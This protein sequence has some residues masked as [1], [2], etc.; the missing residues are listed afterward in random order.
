[1]YHAPGGAKTDENGKRWLSV[2]DVSRRP[3]A[4][5][6]YFFFVTLTTTMTVGVLHP[7][8]AAA[9]EK[10]KKN[11]FFACSSSPRPW[12]KDSRQSRPVD[13]PASPG[14]LRALRVLEKRENRQQKEDEEEAR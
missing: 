1:M 2:Y 11:A 3:P 10:P 6:V 9:T 7:A 13:P 5:G 14:R 12:A 4:T 8:T